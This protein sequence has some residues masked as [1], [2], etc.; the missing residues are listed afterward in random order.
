MFQFFRRR[1]ARRLSSPSSK[2]RLVRP[3]VEQLEERDLPSVY[4]P[5]QIRQAYGFNAAVGDG[6]GQTI[7]IVDAYGDPNIFADLNTFDQAFGITP[8][9]PSTSFL[10]VAMPQ[11]TPGTD[12][13]WAMEISLDVEWAHAIAPGAHILLVEAV[14]SNF[15]NLLSAVQYAAAQPGVSV[16]SISW[17]ASEF[18]GENGFDS[19]FT[20]PAGHQGVTFVAASGDNG[21]PSY[22]AASP[23]V[24]SVGGTSL[25][26]SSSGTYLSETAWS[27]SG[28]GLSPYEA[29]PGY[30]HSVQSSG[31]RSTP[32]VAYNGDPN[33][34]YMVY[35]SVPYGGITGWW[36]VGGTSAG[37]PQWAALIAIAN[38]DRVAAGK[39]TLDGP[40]QTLPALYSLPSSD[41]HD[42]TSGSNNGYSAAAGY[43]EVTG[44]G[45]PI[46]NLVIQGLVNYGSPVSTTG[47]GNS[48]GSGTTS[49][50]SGTTSGGGT[51]GGG[52]G[53]GHDGHHSGRK[54]HGHQIKQHAVA[55]A[56]AAPV[57]PLAPQPAAQSDSADGPNTAT[58]PLFQPLLVGGSASPTA[59]PVAFVGEGGEGPFLD[60]PVSPPPLLVQQPGEGAAD[61]SVSSRVLV[62][63]GF[64]L[65]SNVVEDALEEEKLAAAVEGYFQEEG[66]FAEPFERDY[67]LVPPPAEPARPA[68]A[69][70]LAATMAVY[71]KPLQDEQKRRAAVPRSVP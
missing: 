33:T 29:E 55:A 69:A 11:G 31:E 8:G 34:G 27:G 40:T 46:A 17:G 25:I 26:I 22:P 56:V 67:L 64:P 50:G 59:G 38:E 35:D 47:G 24:L 71:W 36:Q 20:T 16:V 4:T 60:A 23:N 18:A 63:A 14:N 41:F 6:S 3:K 13:S 39:T 62:T 12:P 65:P 2:R 28:G 1:G 21:S 10:T 45:S 9:L 52:H 44:R 37:A 48:G 42:I 7:A 58:V 43:D 54:Q 5:A 51:T 15:Y 57:N 61:S 32:D 19:Y 66:L 68:L 53:S 30:Q 70:A 49:G